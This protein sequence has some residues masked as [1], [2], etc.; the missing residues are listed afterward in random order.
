[1][2][3]AGASITWDSFGNG[4][5]VQPTNYKLQIRQILLDHAAKEGEYN[6]VQVN[7]LIKSMLNLDETPSGQ[8]HQ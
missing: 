8:Q 7:I 1:M 3:K 2:D 5:D 4:D 6:V